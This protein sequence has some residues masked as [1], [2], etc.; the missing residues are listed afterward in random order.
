MSRMKSCVTMLYEEEL[1][2]SVIWFI[3]DVICEKR[4]GGDTSSVL[5]RCWHVEL[6]GPVICESCVPRTAPTLTTPPHPTPPHP[7]PPT[8]PTKHV[9]Y[10]HPSIHPCM[11]CVAYPTIPYPYIQKQQICSCFTQHQHHDPDLLTSSS[12]EAIWSVT[13]RIRHLVL[14]CFDKDQL[15]LILLVDLFRVRMDLILHRLDL[16]LRRAIRVQITRKATAITSFLRDWSATVLYIS[17]A[18][19]I[20]QPTMY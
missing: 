20:K 17:A 8:Q 2:E 18:E 1:C 19:N 9:S 3:Y 12:F 6:S 7:T 10:I 5:G 11:H 14:T 13:W 15:H 16:I 4:G